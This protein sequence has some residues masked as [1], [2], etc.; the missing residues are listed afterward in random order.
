MNN[1]LPVT[2]NLFSVLKNID[3]VAW[4][5]HSTLGRK[6]ARIFEL[7]QDDSGQ[8]IALVHCAPGASA[9]SHLHT[10]HETF[11]ILDGTFEDDNGVYHHGELICYAPGSE[12]AWRTPQG[13]LIYAVW[14]GRVEA[15]LT[16][17]A[18]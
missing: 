1:G 8:R 3:S 13:A 7:F 16:D 4:E 11:L 15:A 17:V 18:A 12:H 2:L 10:G 9:K 14:G 6:D 5:A